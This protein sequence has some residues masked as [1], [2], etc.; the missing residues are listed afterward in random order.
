MSTQE[1]P[2]IQATEIIFEG[3]GGSGKTAQLATL[4]HRLISLQIPTLIT[5]SPRID[6]LEGSFFPP[7][8]LRAY[9]V[10]AQ[11]MIATFLKICE[12]NELEKEIEKLNK[13]GQPTPVI[14][15]DGWLASILAHDL[16]FFNTF[17]RKAIESWWRIFGLRLNPS[18][19]ATLLFDLDPSI[20]R[21][22][23]QKKPKDRA[24]VNISLEQASLVRMSYLTLQGRYKNRWRILNAAQKP[25]NL[26]QQ[27]LQAVQ[28]IIHIK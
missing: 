9:P 8:V 6:A 27:V 15:R 11:A 18:R 28:E 19:G 20:A 3:I 13:Q 2:P 22:R 21:E 25:V 5:P 7:E 4:A 17:N 24:D 14:L 10:L 1:K 26:N 12:K 16:N 23:Q